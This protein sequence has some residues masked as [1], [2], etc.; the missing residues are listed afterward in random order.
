MKSIFSFSILVL[1]SAFSFGQDSIPFHL[2]DHNNLSIETILNNE[3]T[4]HL[5]FHTAVSGLSLTKE[6]TENLNSI[7]WDSSEKVNSWGGQSDARYSANNSLSVGSFQWDSLAIWEDEHSGPG[8]GGKFGPDLFE[9]KHV[10]INFDES[11]LIIHEE[12]PETAS[13]FEKLPLAVNHGMMFL[14]GSSLTGDKHIANDFLIHS[15]Y[16][17][18]ILYDDQFVADHQLGT[19]IEIT[20][21]QELK[22]SYGNVI[23]TKKGTLKEFRIGNEV[24]SNVPVGFFEGSI[25]RQKIS[26]IGGE[27]L[28]RFNLII[29]ADRSDIY[30]RPSHFKSVSSKE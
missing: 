30:I 21:E 17:G 9:G 16:G 19:F 6:A 26:V 27:L 13:S 29:N 2:T 18:A 8:T 22:D 28:K 23:K 3:D 1:A 5:M 10:E 4:I 20:D 12:L 25:G 11:L 14:S 15:G 24:F 7:E